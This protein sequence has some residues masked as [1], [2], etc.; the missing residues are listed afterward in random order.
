M[1]IEDKI[2]E[3]FFEKASALYHTMIKNNKEQYL[4]KSEK[5]FAENLHIFI[6]C[7][8]DLKR[9]VSGIDYL[10][11]F[12]EEETEIVVEGGK[13]RER[14]KQ[15]KGFKGMRRVKEDESLGKNKKKEKK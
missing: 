1:V 8:F 13:I 14:I 6:I 4:R 10:R 3:P 15:E 7:L 12:T 11:L 5:K 2:H 9:V